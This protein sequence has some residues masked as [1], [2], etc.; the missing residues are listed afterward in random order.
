M[1]MNKK[2]VTGVATGAI[3]LAG[4][5][6]ALAYWT[7]SGNGSGTGTTTAGASNLTIW[8]KGTVTG[9]YPGGPA[10]PVVATITNNADNSAFVHQV[11]VSILQVQKPYG[12]TGTCDASDFELTSDTIKVDQE[13]PSKSLIEISGAGIHFVDKAANQDACKNATISLHL[14]A[15]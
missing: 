8:Q 5:G 4:S 3:V 13:I 12:A 11:V 14:A 1:R 10:M 7:A 6:V 15:S 9:V 2:L